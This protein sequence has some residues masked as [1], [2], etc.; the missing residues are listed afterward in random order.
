M[1][2]F[3]TQ[4]E[5]RLLR[6]KVKEQEVEIA[7]LRNHVKALQRIIENLRKGGGENDD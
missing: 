4:V 6:M 3:I 7:N 5:G 1:D 2:D